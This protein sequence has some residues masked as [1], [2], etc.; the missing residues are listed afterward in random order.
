MKY[1][2][3][4]LFIFCI[5]INA[6]KGKADDAKKNNP[7]PPPVVDVI[8]ASYQSIENHIEVNG[9]VLP[10]EYVELRP[11]I[12]GLL[13]YLNV[14]EGSFV[15]KGTVIARINNA[16]LTS[17][18]GKLKVQLDLAKTT[19]QR[20]KKLLDMSGINRADYDVALN[21]VNNIKADMNLQQV[22]IGKSVVTAPFSG[23]VGLRQ[24]SPGSYVSNSTVL[25]T[26]QKID[27]LKIDF[28]VPVE[29][30][31]A[32]KIGEKITIKM[33]ADTSHV[34]TATIVATEPQANTSTRNMT[35]RAILENGKANAGS[36]VKVI[37]NGVANNKSIMVP[38]NAIIPEDLS[39]MLVTVKN[40]KAVYVKV[41]TGMRQ[42]DN[43][44]VMSGINIGDSVVVSGV[45][46][47][48]PNMPVKVREVKSR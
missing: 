7:K 22:L 24:I 13:T 40:G 32:I 30:A 11:E 12:S 33:D 4:C 26:L 16:D 42:S 45:L 20:Y 37:V 34:Q 47:T 41:V 48:R 10:D 19:E 6:C 23:V 2:I 15:K 29:Y 44:E 38:A 39:K 27:R 14:K 17:Q 35:V 28:A 8:V 9:T 1:S 31:G 3:F 5:F 46:F 43:V 18:L 25:A 36:F 21:Q